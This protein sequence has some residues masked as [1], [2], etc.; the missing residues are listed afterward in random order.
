[1]CDRAERIA[2]QLET[3]GEMEAKN[4]DVGQVVQR[5]KIKNKNA[6]WHDAVS[7]LIHTRIY[8]VIQIQ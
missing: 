7:A 4:N 5:N 6:R 8:L 1:M 3:A 2:G